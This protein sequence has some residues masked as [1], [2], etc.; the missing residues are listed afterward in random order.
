MVPENLNHVEFTIWAQLHNTPVSMMQA[1][2]L[3]MIVDFARVVDVNINSYSM[4]FG[5]ERRRYVCVC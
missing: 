5:V 2:Y 1:R 3:Q 4:T